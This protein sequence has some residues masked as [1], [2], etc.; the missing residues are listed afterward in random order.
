[1]WNTNLGPYIKYD[2]NR[3]LEGGGGVNCSQYK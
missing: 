1:M 3:N 2:R